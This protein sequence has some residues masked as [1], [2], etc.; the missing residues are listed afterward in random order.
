MDDHQQETNSIA[1]SLIEFIVGSIK[2]ISDLVHLAALEAQLAVKTL[3]ILAVL[4]FILGTVMTACWLSVLAVIFFYLLSLHFSM[5]TASLCL[6]GINMLILG[7]L[8]ITMYKLK[9]NL[10]FPNTREQLNH[11][12]KEVQVNAQITTEN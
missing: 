4:V 7:L 9:A 10:F 8:A 1:V 5:L 12:G 2:W 11:H 6:V 3:V